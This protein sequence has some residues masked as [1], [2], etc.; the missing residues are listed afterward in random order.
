MTIHTYQLVCT[1]P[2]SPIVKVVSSR[3]YCYDETGAFLGYFPE[4]V[5]VTSIQQQANTTDSF[6]DGLSLG[7]GVVAAMALAYGIHLLRR[8]L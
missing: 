1:D 3:V 8:A 5:A 4:A 2:G 6:N 7:W